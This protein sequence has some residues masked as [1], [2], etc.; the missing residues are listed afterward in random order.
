M[1]GF[2]TADLT[3]FTSGANARQI[4]MANVSNVARKLDLIN[5][6]LQELEVTKGR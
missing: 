2:G 1:L 4:E 6:M 5:T 3:V